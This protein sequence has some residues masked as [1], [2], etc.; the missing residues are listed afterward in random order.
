M[1]RSNKLH[2]RQGKTLP[3]PRGEST[4]TTDCEESNHR[5][6]APP[7]CSGQN[8]SCECSGRQWAL[9]WAHVTGEFDATLQGGG[10]REGIMASGQQFA[11]SC[12]QEC[13]LFDFTWS[14][15]SFKCVL[16]KSSKALCSVWSATNVQ[17]M[18]YFESTFYFCTVFMDSAV[19]VT[20]LWREEMHQSRFTRCMKYTSISD[21]AT[22][23]TKAKI[24]KL[25]KC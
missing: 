4:A 23:F 8:G 25:L 6:P 17:K 21:N 14:G 18:F 20:I 7:R 11:T 13:N 1:P 12:H 5:H 19:N 3:G 15:D 16:Y 24:C 2:W 9:G 22:Y 10:G